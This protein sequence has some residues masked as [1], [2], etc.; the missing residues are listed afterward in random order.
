MIWGHF[1]P[2]FSQIIDGPVT[3][4]SV[5]TSPQN[6]MSVAGQKRPAFEKQPKKK[7]EKTITH[8]TKWKVSGLKIVWFYK[9]GRNNH[10]RNHIFG[11]D[12]LEGNQAPVWFFFFSKVATFA[13]YNT[14]IHA[15]SFK[16]I[17]HRVLCKEIRLWTPVMSSILCQI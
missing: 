3:D 7:K 8:L 11:I 10:K 5:Q 6:M 15:Q 17:I 12:D 1:I 13:P 14:S 4:V 2:S 9:G 16:P